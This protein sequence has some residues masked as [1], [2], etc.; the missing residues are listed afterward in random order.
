M[1]GKKG[2]YE[3]RIK[4]SGQLDRSFQGAIDQADRELRK[5]YR[6][7]QKQQGFLAGVDGLDA[8]SDK[9]FRL[10]AKGA[11]L[12]AAGIAGIGTASVAAGVSF[13]EQMSSVQAISNASAA[14]MER[15]NA[16]ALEMGRNTQFSATEAGKGL[17]YMAM[18][19]WKTD[20]MIAGLP[21]IL[22]LAAASGEDLGEVS[23]IVTDALTAFGLTAEDAAMFSDVLAEASNASN[24]DV[25][26]MGETFQYVA[27]VAGA[28]KYS[29][30][31][32]SIAIGLMA[33]SGIKGSQAGTALRATLS[34]LVKP[35]KE[36]RKA[37]KTLGFSMTDSEGNLKSFRT[38]MQD[39]RTGFSGLSTAEQTSVAAA[40]A[41][42]EAMSGLLAIVNA[43][44]SDFD[45]LAAAI[46]NSAGSAE[47]MAAVR[48]DNLA[49][50]FTLL[51]SAAEGAGIAI[52]QTMDDVL[53][54]VVQGAS[55]LVN[56]FT[57]SDFLENLA[58]DMPSI[59]REAKQFGAAV[60]DAMDPLLDAGGWFLEHPDVLSG[61]ITGIGSALLT[62]KAANGA[63]TAIKMLGTLSGMT[64]AWPVA[65][66]GLAIGGIVGIGTAIRTAERDA[67]KANLAE[68][69][70]D[71][72][73]SIEEL[74][75]AA[76]HIVSGGGSLFDQL[77]AF[78]EAADSSDQLRESLE[79]GLEAIRKSNWKLSLGIAFDESDTES[80]V[81][82]VDSLVK[83]AQEYITS[84]G[85]EV[86][87]AVG[88][89]FGDEGGELA[90]SS[91]AFYQSL[92]AQMQPLQE[93]L[94]EV[95]NDITEN[96]L[97]LD[98]QQIVDQY[99]T[100]ISDI[101][102]MI[103]EAENSAKMQ[104]IG[105]QYAGADLL[106]GDTFQNLQQ[107]IQEYTDEANAGIDQ[108]YQRVLT[109]LNAQ[110]IAGEQGMEGGISAEEFEAGKS[111]ATQAY[112]EQQAQVIT[113]G[114]QI[115]ADAI[116]S[117]YGDEIQPALDAVNQQIAE[118]LPAV[119]E[120]ST[121]AA[122]YVNG[123]DNLIRNALSGVDLSSES[124]DAILMLY[125]NMLPTR[126]DLEQ[127]SQQMKAN[128]LSPSDII[129]ESL[130]ELSGIGAVAGDQGSMEYL[131]GNI[132]GGNEDWAL[133]AETVEQQ[134]GA[135]PDAV[136][137]GLHSKDEEVQSEARRLIQLVET[138]FSAGIDVT[139]PVD[140]TTVRNYRNGTVK[141]VEHHASGG[142]MSRP[143]LSWFAEE[144][145]EMAIPIDGS[146]R[147][148]SL[149]EE[150][151]R[152]LGAYEENNYSKTY[153]AMAQH[154]SSTPSV[155]GAMSGSAPVYQPIMN[156]YGSASRED[157]EAVTQAGFE[158]F[159]EWYERLM[160][161]QARTAF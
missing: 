144:S 18:A 77:D 140:I 58:E 49:G 87:L 51:T 117:T 129:Q 35:T 97:T 135:V 48:I 45:N 80:Y 94:Q 19:G 99:L 152:L 2:N 84:S 118:G 148:R 6:D 24:T 159:R 28:L 10:V 132:L 127:L 12:A 9:T 139:L 56:D 46:D 126:E 90:E 105:A 155:S 44:Q 101:T 131:V 59:R 73:L 88:I 78:G 134:T 20:Q 34:R 130:S 4:I 150:T 82:S 60:G 103:T 100:D 65:A 33:N 124:Q 1:A 40:L 41:G 160:Y 142:L 16:L 149:W 158:Q 23:D 21:S 123:F 26:L 85:Y 125:Q 106:S 161:E 72:T 83:N 91:D 143:T 81:S 31:D 157:V 122:D 7:A 138:E 133:L 17:E 50:D 37:M 86:S 52:Y 71:I 39:L 98:K 109:N 32:V 151:G 107:S 136:I 11:S 15:L 108:A 8:F 74:N 137:E 92:Y 57:E 68:H 115:M 69:F 120:N 156:F 36:V 89:V 128:G 29:I 146:A 114:Y 14:D 153:D 113:N 43:S 141:G 104:M 121:T 42:Q 70:G 116:M 75:E 55:E 112:Y 30:Q 62:F 76:R 66:A 38:I 119:M 5:L 102:S 95:L 22:N 13:E 53:R 64:A 27:P 54:E 67:A 3:T 145:P 147:S 111:Q 110:R 96:G 79:E 25:A 63:T 93:G 154:I 61:T 47:K